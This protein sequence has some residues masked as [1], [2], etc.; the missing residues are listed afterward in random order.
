MRQDEARTTKHHHTPSIKAR[1]PG[2][3]KSN[4][5]PKGRDQHRNWAR[6]PQGTNHRGEGSNN[7]RGRGA[8]NSQA[9]DKRK[10]APP[11]P[12]WHTKAKE[13]TPAKTQ[14]E[15]PAQT[16]HNKKEPGTR[17]NEEKTKDKPTARKARPKQ[18]TRKKGGPGGGQD[19]K[20]ARKKTPTTQQQVG[21]NHYAVP[22]DKGHRRPKRCKRETQSQG[23]RRRKGEGRYVIL[24]VV[25]SR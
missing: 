12:E 7:R 14:A 19:P 13:K 16:K 24:R 17:G 22:R 6:T 2:R 10:E 9:K 25:Y 3:H 11:H 21:A 4:Q 1:Q 5:I 20:K 15:T 18:R 8:G 23:E